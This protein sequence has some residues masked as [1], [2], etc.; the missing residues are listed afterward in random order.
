MQT[1]LYFQKHMVSRLHLTLGKEMANVVS[2]LRRQLN[3]IQQTEF[4]GK[5]NGAV[6]IVMPISRLS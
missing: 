4:L 2:R 1:L 5:I 3:Q 6:E